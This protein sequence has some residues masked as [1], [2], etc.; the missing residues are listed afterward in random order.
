M[1]QSVHELGAR[2]QSEL[3]ALVAR[4]YE[5]D[6]S[7]GRGLL[8]QKLRRMAELG[9]E[10]TYVKRRKIIEETDFTKAQLMVMLK[11]SS[12]IIALIPEDVEQKEDAPAH[13][14]MRGLLADN[15]DDQE[16]VVRMRRNAPWW[17]MGGS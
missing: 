1:N 11:D 10:E 15:N 8:A 9:R 13:Q 2:Q 7:M 12:K 6:L 3:D 17:G 5:I 4:N 16:S 14:G